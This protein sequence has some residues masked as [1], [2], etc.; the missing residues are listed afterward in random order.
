MS[1][2]RIVSLRRAFEDWK[3]YDGGNGDPNLEERLRRYILGQQRTAGE[4]HSALVNARAQNLTTE[5]E[6]M[7]GEIQATYLEN[8]TGLR[9]REFG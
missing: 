3:K 7:L 8:E 5:A 6:A 2:S 9:G 4:T 1:R